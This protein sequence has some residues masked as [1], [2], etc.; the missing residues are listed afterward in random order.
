MSAP[1]PQADPKAGYL[2]Q[3]A[4]IDAAVARVLDSG[5]YILGE[6]VAA[7]E[8]EFAAFQETGYGIGVASGT[9]A[10][11]LGLRALGVGPGDGVVTVSHTAVATVAAIE[12][13]GAVP[14][15]A[16]IDRGYA[17]APASLEAALATAPVPVKAVV[18]VHI[19]GQP[20]DMRAILPIARTHELKVLEDCAQSHGARLDGKRAGSFGDAAAFSFYPTKNLGGLGDGGLVATGD[21]EIAAHVQSLRAY[22]WRAVRYVSDEAGDNSRLDELQAAI[23]RVKLRALAA[24]TA[25]RQAIAAA[26][27]A[28]LGDRAPWRRPGAEP[29]F[30]L[31][32]IEPDDRDGFA[33]ALKAEGIGTNVHYPVP[34]HLQPAYAGRIAL[35]PGGLPATERAATRVLSLPLFPQMT[36]AQVE[37]V[38]EA[39]RRHA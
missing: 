11:A 17:M 21:A 18:P 14:L 32:V 37:R 22:G 2:A 38:C 29:V 30:H 34:V 8:R 19:Y 12:L 39:L 16:D 9:A 35:P 1:I 24:D 15:L 25:R 28:V 31:Y 26:Y 27:D 33:A 10:L 20:A 4:A 36:D 7:F 6:E 13:I 3:K 5:W 23:L